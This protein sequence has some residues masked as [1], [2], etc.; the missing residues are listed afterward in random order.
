MADFVHLHNHTHYSLLDAACTPDQLI[1]AAKADG[2]DALALTD[3]GVM[4]GCYEFYKK[5][6]KAGIKPIIGCEVYLA[7]GSRFDKIATKKGIEQRNYN[8]LVLLAKNDIGYKNLMKLV[9]LGHTEG[10]YYKPRI[11]RELLVQ[12]KEGLIALSACLAGVVNEPLM[13]G[14]YETAKKNARWF[15]EQFG[16]DW[17]IELQDHGLPE[18][19]LILE[20][21][22]RIAEELG[23]KMIVSND[24]HYIRKEHAIP[25]NVHLL[26]KDV[27]AATAGTFDVSKLRYKVPEMYFKTQQEMKELFKKFPQA[28]ENTLEVAEKINV[29]LK[30]DL[31][32]PIFPIPPESKAQNLDEYLE[33]LTMMGLEKRYK[34]VP[35]EVFDRAS[36]ELDVIRKMGYAG[37][38]LIVQDFIQ[39]ARDRGVSVGPGRG[40][41]AG[42]LVAYALGITNIDPIPYD[43]LFERFLNPDRVSMPDI[44][45]D[46]NDEKRDVVIEYVKEKYGGDAVA[47]IITFG[48]LSTRAVI[49]D[50]GRVLGVPLATINSIT[51][52]IPVIMGKVTKI[53]DALELAELRWVKES[54]DPK[55]RQMIEYATVLEGFA[56][57]TSLH[58]AGVVIAP[59]PITDY[60]PLYKTPSTNACTMFTMKDLE[61]AGLLKMDFL[62]LATLS[63]I[64]RT[65]EMIEQNYNTKI[66]LDAIDFLDPATYEMIGQG[67]TLAIF[68]FESDKMTEYLRGLKPKNLEELTAMNALYRPGPMD[69]IP[70]FIDRKFARKEI[71][72][73]HPLMKDSLE[74]TYGVIVYQEQVMQLVRDLAGFSLAQADLMRRAMGK[75]DDKL[76]AEQR[77]IFIEGAKTVQNIESGLA[78]QIFDLI[79]KF[80]SYGFNK[81][82]SVAYSYLAYQTA[83]LKRHYTAEFLASNMT[84]ELNNLEKITS[85]IEEAKKF[86][87]R[88]L[89]PDVNKSGITF[90]AADPQTIVFGMAG[91][92]NVGVPAVESVIKARESGGNFTSFFDFV[93]R[94]DIRLVNKRALEALIATGAFDSLAN[95]NRAQLFECIDV[96]LDYAKSF[97][98]SASNTMDSLFGDDAHASVVE[99][100]LPDIPAWSEAERLERE[101]QYLNFYISGHPLQRYAAHINSF[102]TL[103]LG[104]KDSPLIGKVVR[105]CGMLTGVRTRLDKRENTIAFSTIEDF[106]GKAEAIFWS[107][108][109]RQYSEFIQEGMAVMLIGKSEMRDEGALKIIADEVIPLDTAIARF[110]KGYSLRMNVDTDSSALES[111]RSMFGTNGEKGITVSFSLLK[112]ETPFAQYVAKDIKLPINEETAERLIKIFGRNNVRFLTES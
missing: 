69:N 3:H 11:D 108:A 101:Y 8:H 90:M 49:K 88:V 29:D 54:D 103:Y 36:F 5:S 96:A 70:D 85:L 99:P 32:M 82:H 10:F 93:R 25:H 84:S 40:S 28:V 59:G 9:S 27:S 97:T 44:D 52:K 100:K 17:Y 62:G 6:K 86:N 31:K 61:D 91:I 7:T 72:Y 76:M 38:F 79:Q 47:Q 74:K 64:D 45:I 102:S 106:T 46:F 65:L 66:D 109:Y 1:Y 14:D 42:S 39:A 43:L 22:P 105:V 87:I 104:K 63:I 110:A 55:L 35:Q 60:V 81:S 71:T 80:A 48:T 18:D 53:K 20:G 73:L 107:D 56:R 83:W 58:A 21:A 23:I 98:D 41:A 12:Y 2:Q 95:G 16:E 33:E 34:P 57:N 92:K 78:G 67:H 94:V 26:I 4:F 19:K 15:K 30:T 111:V 51:E 89:P 50:V 68:Q 24:C 77:A 37:Y 75:K 13:R 112:D